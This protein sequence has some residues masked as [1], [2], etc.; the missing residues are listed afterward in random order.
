MDEVMRC[1]QSNS[2][3]APV[4][5]FRALS[6]RMDMVGRLASVKGKG[7]GHGKVVEFYLPKTSG[8]RNGCL[9]CKVERVIEFCTQTKKSPSLDQSVIWKLAGVG[10]G[11]SFVF[12]TLKEERDEFRNA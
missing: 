5:R 4:V 9:R 2:A 3:Q 11:I 12:A 8:S 7:D 1:L 6:L 10:Q